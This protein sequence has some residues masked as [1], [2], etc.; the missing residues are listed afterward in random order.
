MVLS[1]RYLSSSAI[2]LDDKANA[3]VRVGLV[4][5]FAGLATGSLWAKFTWGAWWTNDKQLNGAAIT[6]LIYLAY[7]LLRTSMDDEEKRGRISAVYNIFA[8]AM[9]LLFIFVLPRLGDS[10]ELHPGKG[11]NPAFS[12]YDLDN[13]L[14]M[15]FYPAVICW[16]GVGYW[17]YTIRYRMQRVSRKIDQ[18][19]EE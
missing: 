13:K 5:A 8:F 9:M 4:F 12:N 11:G 10:I 16:I 18:R 15:L 2:D 6:T 19:Y 14:R 7:L 3:A 17:I 1:I